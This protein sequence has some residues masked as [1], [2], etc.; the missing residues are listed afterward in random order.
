MEESKKIQLVDKNKE[1][2]EEWEAQFHDA[3]DVEV[4]C[5]DFFGLDTDC[6][7]S[8]ANSFGYMDGSLDAVITK[9]LGK[10]V[11][12]NLQEK[13]KNSPMGELLVGQ[14]ELVETGDEHIPYCIS[15][16]TMRVPS[17]LENTVNVY[18]AAKAVFN[19]FKNEDK[20]NTITMSGLGTGVGQVPYPLCAK[21]M[22]QA[23]DDV[24]LEKY[25]F[26]KTWIDAQMRH[27]LMF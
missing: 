13:I 6:V 21:Q 22:R 3:D 20:I 27:Q 4:Y 14:T 2:C 16:P 25:K 5:G 15:A 7:V 23:Y 19:L 24:W 9:R 10:Q 26:P 1:M 8:P 18:L 17:K 11:Q 12:N